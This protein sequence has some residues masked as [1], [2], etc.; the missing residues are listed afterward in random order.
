MRTVK[1]AFRDERI[2]DTTVPTL[3]SEVAV[4]TLG[5]RDLFVD[6]HT[7]DRHAKT[8]RAYPEWSSVANREL[9]LPL[10]AII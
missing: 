2:Y 6:T 1:N 5:S 7:T 9:H 3:F 8:A 10:Q 4:L